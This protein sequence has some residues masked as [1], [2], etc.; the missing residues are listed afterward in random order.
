METIQYDGFREAVDD[1]RYATLL[2]QTATEALEKSASSGNVDLAY[3]A[4]SALLFLAEVDYGE[5]DL[6][7]IRLE[8]IR[9]ILK[10]RDMMNK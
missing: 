5:C 10:L 7:A 4:K 2:K 9:H 1:V 3:A 6:Q 8:I